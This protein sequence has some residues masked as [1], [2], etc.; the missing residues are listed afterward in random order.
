MSSPEDRF[1][2]QVKQHLTMKYGGVW[3]TKPRT[4]FGVAGVSDVLWCFPP[5]GRFVALEF[6]DPNGSYKAT[7]LQEDFLGEVDKAG[8]IAHVID[9]WE[10]VRDLE[11]DLRA[12][13]ESLSLY[14]DDALPT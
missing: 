5:S 13:A 11:V 8:G 9:S 7:K 4:R 3:I 2:G 6:K 14:L 1:K 12:S 10:A